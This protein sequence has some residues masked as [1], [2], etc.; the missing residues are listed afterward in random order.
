[1][2]TPTT[3]VNVKYDPFDVYCGRTMPGF[4]DVGFGNPTG[5]RWGNR[6]LA[7]LDFGDYFL[8]RVGDRF[9]RGW[10]ERDYPFFDQEFINAV[11]SLQGKRLGC[12]C[13]PLL[14]HCEV[15]VQYLLDGCPA[16]HSFMRKLSNG[17]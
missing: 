9:D 17:R 4:V 12:W 1:M 13:A 11:R 3:I 8:H 16:V 14:C 6:V 2:S 5:I 10:Y 15:Y 7:V